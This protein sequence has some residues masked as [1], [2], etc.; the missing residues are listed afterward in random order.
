MAIISKKIKKQF[1]CGECG[2]NHP[3]WAGQCLDCKAWNSLTEVI[4]DNTISPLL[5]DL[6]PNT[7]Q[8][9]NTVSSKNYQRISTGISELDKTL[10][11]EIGNYGLVEGSVVLI[12][13]DPG[14]G[15]STLILQVLANINNSHN[16]LYVSGEESIN[17]ISSR[18]KR[19]KIDSDIMLFSETSLENIIATAKK[20]M[21]KVMVIDSIQTVMSSEVS[22]SAGSVTQVRECASILTTFAK[23][24]NTT[25]IMIG[26]V[27]KGGALAGPRI[28]EHMVDCVLAFEGD[29]GGR[30]RIVR[31][32]KN[33]FGAIN[34]IS[35]FAMLEGG[36]KQIENPSAIFLSNST[37][38]CAG[39][40]VM[41]TC[42]ATRPM[43]VEVQALV[44]D[45]SGSPKRI[46]VGLDQ[47]RLVLQLAILHKHGDITTG[48]MDCFVN[49]VGGVKITETASDLS[50][51]MAVFS[52]LSGKIIPRKMIIFGEVGL[53][54]EVRPV[55][56]GNE[57]LKEAHKQGFEMAIIPSQNKPKNFK[58]M[59]IIGVEYLVDAINHLS[60]L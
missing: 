60:N 23:K 56:N 43:L 10:G 38:D 28:L 54:G 33:R 16:T 22:S 36:L 26:H 11:G 50:V 47:N 58:G 45:T 8:S 30:Y 49:V 52:S 37:K 6:S 35:V 29:A 9:L 25:L 48:D 7:P 51:I 42:E 44:D 14:I 3:Q 46:C 4:I 40:V 12:G 27:T 17:Q 59:E 2:S 53:T 15:K 13:G 20:Q 55:F 57:R 1:V 32:V 21:P 18:A 24:T 41:V 34:E 31:G 19:L 39:R 5:Q